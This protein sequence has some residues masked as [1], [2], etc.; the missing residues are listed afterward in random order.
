MLSAAFLVGCE[1]VLETSLEKQSVNLLAPVDNLISVNPEQ[2]FYWEPLRGATKY[3]LQVVYPKFDSI[4]QL[5]VDTTITTNQFLLTI[6]KGN[7]Q[8]RVRASN[9]STESDYGQIRRI[10]IQ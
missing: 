2:T 1:E 5:V 7:F 9:A 8:W 10:I 4:V 3:Q 6:P